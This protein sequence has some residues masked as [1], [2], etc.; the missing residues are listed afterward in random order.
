MVLTRRTV[1]VATDA[2]ARPIM[3]AFTTTSAWTNIPQGDRASG[4]GPTALVTTEVD[5]ACGDAGE[6]EESADC[7]SARGAF[8]SASEGATPW[9]ASRAGAGLAGAATAATGCPDA[10]SAP[11]EGC[12]A[13]AVKDISDT[14]MVRSNS[15]RNAE[16]P[17]LPRLRP[18][19]WVRASSM[20]LYSSR[21]TQQR[22]GWF[23]VP[24]V[25]QAACLDRPISRANLADRE[26][27]DR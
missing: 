22:S 9:P 6:D 23:Q 16:R 17:R 19:C 11:T 12:S 8:P 15:K 20:F 10:P 13:K 4:K 21:L 2:S 25:S 1:Q 7:G 14:T 5:C 24:V 18:R 26:I 27:M 3:T